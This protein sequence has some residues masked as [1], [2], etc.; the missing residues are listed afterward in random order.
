MDTGEVVEINKKTP[1]FACF[2][3]LI[4]ELEDKNHL[5]L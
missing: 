4:K 1:S 3:I 2:V 5:L